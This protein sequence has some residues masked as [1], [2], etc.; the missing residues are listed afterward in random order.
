M[1]RKNNFPF[2]PHHHIIIIICRLTRQAAISLFSQAHLNV[3]KLFLGR[4]TI[5]FEYQLWIAA[6][7]REKLQPLMKTKC[8]SL[9]QHRSF[10]AHIHRR[11]AWNTS[12]C[13]RELFKHHRTLV[14]YHGILKAR[15]FSLVERY[16]NCGMK[17]LRRTIKSRQMV[18][19]NSF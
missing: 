3:Y 10:I 11:M 19:E 13:K 14:P 17:N 7:T 8:V 9:S 15:D 16:L 6:P 2:R 5:T 1:S 12:G 4:L 18:S